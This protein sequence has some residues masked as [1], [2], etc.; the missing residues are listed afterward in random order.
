MNSI[1]FR[2][3]FGIRNLQKQRKVPHHGACCCC[4]SCGYDYD[5]CKCQDNALVEIV[6]HVETMEAR[7]ILMNLTSTQDK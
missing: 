5:D 7:L 6:E 2:K 1:D 4:Q 3:H